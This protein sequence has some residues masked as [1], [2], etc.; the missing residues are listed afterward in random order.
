MDKQYFMNKAIKEAYICFKTGDIPVGAVVV[1]NNK[2]IGKGHNNRINKYDVTN[3]AEI[4]AIRNA[5][6]NI[7]DW[8][9]S[10]CDLYVTL[11]PCDMC[12]EVIKNARIKNVY[13]L[14]KNS[15]NHHY[16][17]TNKCTIII[18]ENLMN[19][20]KKDYQ[21]FFKTTLNR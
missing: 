7:K 16:A 10:E 12:F 17:K 15:D 9:L 18:N 1:N 8:R 4:I 13:Y 2:I 14:I 20:Y 5:E 6:Q 21:N 11:E 3:H 19:K